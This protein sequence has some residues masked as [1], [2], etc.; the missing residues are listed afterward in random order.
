VKQ[1]GTFNATKGV[2]RIGLHDLAAVYWNLQAPQLYG[3]A[4][5]RDEAKIA[6][7]GALVAET[8]VHTGRSPEDKFIVRDA[9][10]ENTIW[11]DNNGAIAPEQFET[12]F[13]DFIEHAKGRELFVQDL[14][15]VA[16]PSARVNIRI[17]TEFAWHSLFIRNLLI[18]PE[19]S[20]L[21]DFVPDLTIVALPS[22]RADP[23]R[24][25]CRTETVIACDFSRRIVLIGGTS[26]AGEMKKAVFTYLNYNL[27][28]AGV[29][30]MHCS[31]NSGG[32]NEVA[33]F[34]GLSGTGKTTLSADPTRTLIGDDEHGWGE[35][36]VFNFEGGCY[37]KAI[38]L[39]R[40]AEPEIYATTE[41]FGTVMENVTLDPVTHA[42]DFDDDSKTENTRVAY[43]LDFIAN[44]SATGRDGPPRNIVMLTCDAFGVL[45][46][47][48]KLDPAQ[49][50]Y[51]F[52]SGYT[53]RVAGTEKGVTEP[54]ATFSACF[55]AP[56]MPRH[57]SVYGN[58]LRDLIERHHVDCWLIN[59]G[60]TGGIA[61]V[62]RRMPIP[63]TRRL[64]GAALDG[65]L[66]RA[67]FRIDPQ[68]GLAVPTSV[69]GVEP[70]ILEP[71]K[72]WA[73][74]AEFA[75]TAARLIEMFKDN[76]AK[77]ELHVDE[78]VRGAGP[79]PRLRVA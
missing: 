66:N 2:D 68:F 1:F 21:D 28:E 4:L 39:S 52:L 78:D 65:S 7:G 57:P 15:A 27:P 74:R 13:G 60:W 29:L 25:G 14:Y 24:H 75:A 16:E 19:L 63:V 34:F 73:S 18:R 72:T 77:F 54:S 71:I 76:F 55:G 42:P 8:G 51:H 3:E 31:A 53:A 32:D 62:G 50:M 48:A 17:F 70:H 26:Y 40:E 35:M 11:W 58:L 64:L 23:K 37:A 69:R 36:G 22:F 44:A 5:R 67:N 9:S 33:I 30:P 41:R 10:T 46:P 38:K 6:C 79:A 56:F 49:A 43:P 45:P 61:G 20:E 47:I 12:L 59:T